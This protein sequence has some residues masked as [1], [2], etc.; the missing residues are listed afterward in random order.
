MT[1]RNS[2]TES[3]QSKEPENDCRKFK[4]GKCAVERAEK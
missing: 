3:V 2:K 4:N 1:V